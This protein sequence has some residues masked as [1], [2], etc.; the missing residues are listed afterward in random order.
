MV[1]CV[2]VY[3]AGLPPFGVE[4]LLHMSAIIKNKE[5]KKYIKKTKYI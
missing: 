3:G 5:I 1:I 2:H 4:S